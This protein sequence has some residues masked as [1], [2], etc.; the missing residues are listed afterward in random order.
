MLIFNETYKYFIL[1]F[2]VTSSALASVPDLITALSA[3]IEPVPAWSVLASNVTAVNTCPSTWPVNVALSTLVS[4]VPPY[5]IVWSFAVTVTASLF[6]AVTVYC[7]VTS[8]HFVKSVGMNLT[9][10]VI[11]SYV[12]LTPLYVIVSSTLAVKSAPFP[13]T[14]ST[15]VVFPLVTSI[16]PATLA[17]AINEFVEL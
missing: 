2:A 4:I 15:Y 10:I 13:L 8:A 11:S 1:Y 16:V 3:L 9:V 5:V 12:A 14:I 7:F 6:T 17:S